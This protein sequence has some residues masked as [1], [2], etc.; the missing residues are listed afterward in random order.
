MIVDSVRQRRDAQHEESA[1]GSDEVEDASKVEAARPKG[2]KPSS[3]RRI[4]LAV[5]GACTVV[6]GAYVYGSRVDLTLT[7]EDRVYAQRMLEEG[8]V[9]ARPTPGDFASELRFISEVQRVVL[10]FAPNTTDGIAHGR[11]REPADLYRERHGMCF[12]RSRVVEKILRVNGFTTRHV[13]AYHKAPIVPFASLFMPK[14]KSHAF[15]EVKTSKGWLMVN[16]NERWIS[17]ND[18]LEPIDTKGVQRDASRGE[19]R[20]H[21]D[22]GGGTADPF[23]RS[24]FFFIFGLYSRHGGFYPPYNHVPD[25]SWSEMLENVR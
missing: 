8:G 24:Q 11:T 10:E 20:W 7:D 17:V 5:L 19:I 3:A 12:D 25:V 16:P 9:T 23:F 4:R 2:A 1:R 14:A 6:G 21:A 22:Y 15:T 18:R 13:S